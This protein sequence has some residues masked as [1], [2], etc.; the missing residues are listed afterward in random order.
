MPTDAIT[1][2]ALI[3]PDLVRLTVYLTPRAFAAMNAAAEANG[4]TP[5]DTVNRALV[6]YGRESSPEFDRQYAAWLKT[7][8][9]KRVSG[10][11]S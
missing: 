8:V 6:I 10:A 3:D 1:E 7:E 9:A 4:D 2:P 11:A 5:T